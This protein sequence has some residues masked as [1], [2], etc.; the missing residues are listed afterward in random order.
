M[1]RREKV[2]RQDSDPEEPSMITALDEEMNPR[3]SI[4]CTH[5]EREL[6]KI[7]QEESVYKGM[8]QRHLIR[9]ALYALAD[10]HDIEL[11]FGGRL[12]FRYDQ[13][14]DPDRDSEDSN[15]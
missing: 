8:S 1:S 7:L 4:H 12:T 6:M 13:N 9:D 5:T 2:K 3:T 11:P 15:S 14:N 10:A